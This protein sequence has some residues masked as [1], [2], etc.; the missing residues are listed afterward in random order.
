MA[1]HYTETVNIASQIG[2]T[3]RLLRERAGRSLSDLAAEAGLS[4]TTL[5]GIEQGEANPTLSTLWSLAAALDVPLGRLL[6]DDAPGTTVVRAD[7]GPRISGDAVR[8]RLLHRIH[9]YGWVEVYQLDVDPA[10]QRSAPHRPGVEECLTVIEGRIQTGP[11]DEPSE[12]AAGD[13][14]HFAAARPHVYKGLDGTNRAILLMIH[15]SS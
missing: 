11:A 13:S 6:A 1:Y 12:L 8:A 15:H 10:G 4:K 14:I 9:A 7:E 2:R 3:I 5:H